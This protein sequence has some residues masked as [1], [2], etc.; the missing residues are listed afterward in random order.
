MSIKSGA[1]RQPPL[2]VCIYFKYNQIYE[3]HSSQVSMWY[4]HKITQKKRDFNLMYIDYVSCKLQLT[5]KKYCLNFPFFF[6]F[7]VILSV[8][9][10]ISWLSVCLCEQQIMEKKKNT[11][12]GTRFDIINDIKSDLKQVWFLVYHIAYNLLSN[13]EVVEGTAAAITIFGSF[14]FLFFD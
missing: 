12:Q 5:L 10:I 1:L 13:D 7:T 11:S 4:Q 14:F 9:I 3:F 6:S 8:R 2:N